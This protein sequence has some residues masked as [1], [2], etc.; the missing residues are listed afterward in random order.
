[1]NCLWRPEWLEWWRQLDR[2]RGERK[3][4]V[5]CWVGRMKWN[6]LKPKT[7]SVFGQVGYKAKEGL[8]SY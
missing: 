1:M 3:K 2:T 4:E 5:C 8:Q 6:Y 7:R